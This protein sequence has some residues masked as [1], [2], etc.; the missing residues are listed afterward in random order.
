METISWASKEEARKAMDLLNKLAKELVSDLT[1]RCMPDEDATK[2]LSAASLARNSAITLGFISS[3]IASS[4]VKSSHLAFAINE[5]SD[6]SNLDIDDDEQERIKDTRRN[7]L[8]KTFTAIAEKEISNYQKLGDE[9]AI[10]KAAHELMTTKK[11][12]D[13]IA[14]YMEAA[15][16]QPI[17]IRDCLAEKDS[18]DPKDKA[19]L[20]KTAEILSSLGVNTD[21]LNGDEAND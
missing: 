13:A 9:E 1:L 6:Y 14:T 4:F 12:A 19:S 20:S 21:L 11:G 16:E 3:L 2:S 5:M 17:Y 15:G 18:F 8:I 10:N 7:S